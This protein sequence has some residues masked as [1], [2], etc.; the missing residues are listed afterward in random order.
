MLGVSTQDSLFFYRRRYIIPN[1]MQIIASVTS[2][3]RN[4]IR[5]ASLYVRHLSR[6]L[7]RGIDSRRER[8]GPLTPDISAIVLPS[9][10]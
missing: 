1:A 4:I 8:R 3:G 2:I 9:S 6:A 10:I 7:E 5:T